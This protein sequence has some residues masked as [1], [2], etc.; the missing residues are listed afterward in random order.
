MSRPFSFDLNLQGADELIA[1]LKALPKGLTKGVLQRALMH[2]G[3]PMADY[4]RGLAPVRTGNLR[5]KIGIS[6]KLARG[7]R[8]KL[9]E[10]AVVFVGAS[11]ARHAQLNELGTGP[12]Y[13]KSGKYV[14][15][16]PARPFLRPAF[17]AKVET[18]IELLGEEIWLELEKAAARLGRKVAKLRA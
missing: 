9:K 17:D 3:E 4:A 13:H 18:A 10:K 7:Q 5:S 2:A 11:P 16:M 14:G 15:Q 8:K 1:A 6:T 12:R